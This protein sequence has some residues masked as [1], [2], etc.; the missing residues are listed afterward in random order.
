MTRVVGLATRYPT[1]AGYQH[2]REGQAQF[3]EA[4]ASAANLVSQ[5]PL[6]R[7]DIDRAYSPDLNS[8]KM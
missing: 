8:G 1:A 5:V 7:W 2:S 4:M 6:E 3:W